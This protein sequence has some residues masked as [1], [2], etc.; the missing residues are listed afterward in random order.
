M[1]GSGSG[2]RCVSAGC[3]RLG[4]SAAGEVFLAL[5]FFVSEGPLGFCG[6]SFVAAAEGEGLQGS[7]PAFPFLSPVGG[8]AGLA[9]LAVLGTSRSG[10]CSD[11]WLEGQRLWSAACSAGG[12]RLG[13]SA[14]RKVFLA[15]SFFFYRKQRYRVDAFAKWRA[16]S[17]KQVRLQTTSRASRPPE[18]RGRPGAL[19]YLVAQGPLGFCGLS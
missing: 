11:W 17:T 13:A 12:Q 15:L 4:A 18:Q 9:I 19:S 1:W 2:L 16:Q 6:L 3:Q 14:A 5:L 10:R 8:L 7:F